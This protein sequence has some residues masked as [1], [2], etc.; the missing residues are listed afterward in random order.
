MNTYNSDWRRVG[1]NYIL[2]IKKLP[3]PRKISYFTY[4][5]AKPFYAYIYIYI[6]MIYIYIYIYSYIYIYI[7]YIYIY[8]EREGYH[9]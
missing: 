5:I 8:I 3:E 1:P 6:Y 2:F 7:L 4:Q 9:P